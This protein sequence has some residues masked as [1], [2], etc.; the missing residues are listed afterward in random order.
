MIEIWSSKQE[1]PTAMD[2]RLVIAAAISWTGAAFSATPAV[3]R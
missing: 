2:E 1:K 3:V